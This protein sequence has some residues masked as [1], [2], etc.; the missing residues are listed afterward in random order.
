MDNFALRMAHSVM[1]MQARIHELEH[2]T[3]RLQG[4][5]ERYNELLD[6]SL[7]HS[8]E[9]AFGMFALGIKLAETG[10]FDQKETPA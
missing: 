10:Y 8:K 4:I 3:V 5:E 9:T 6:S 7:R 2:E 1:E